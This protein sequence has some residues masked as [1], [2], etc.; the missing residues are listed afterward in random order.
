MATVILRLSSLNRWPCTNSVYV[1]LPS[2][3]TVFCFSVRSI[4]ISPSLPVQIYCDADDWPAFIFVKTLENG[5]HYARS[6]YTFFPSDPL[7]SSSCWIDGGSRTSACTC[8]WIWNCRSPVR[9]CMR[10]LSHSDAVQMHYNDYD[11]G[12]V[13]MFI[14]FME[15]CRVGPGRT[16][17]AFVFGVCWNYHMFRVILVC[18]RS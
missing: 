1:V 13:F 14:E 11:D 3:F 6:D 7:G 10:S 16:E 12:C 17:S 9:Y 18:M 2:C 8:P 5:V 4:I 15:P